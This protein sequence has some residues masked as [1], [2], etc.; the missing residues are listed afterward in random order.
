M[1]NNSTIRKLYD[2]VIDITSFGFVSAIDFER[3]MPPWLA[4][5]M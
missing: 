4:I 3:F 1:A 2:A 5:K